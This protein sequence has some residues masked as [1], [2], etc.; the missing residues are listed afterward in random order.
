M[1]KK[2][3]N[4]LNKNFFDTKIFV[5]KDTDNTLKNTTGSNHKKLSI[6][7]KAEETSSQELDFLKKIL[8]AV[9]YDLKEDVLLVNITS[10]QHIGF[11]T[12]RTNEGIKDAIIFGMNPQD[13][14][15]HFKANL[16]QPLFCNECRFLFAHSL[17]EIANKKEWKGAL[18]SALQEMFLNN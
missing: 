10:D 5:V 3:N 4:I 7:C 6:V 14:G 11:N 18:W 2:E 12:L 1:D 9:K 13:L 15:L 8:S 17:Q 16:Y